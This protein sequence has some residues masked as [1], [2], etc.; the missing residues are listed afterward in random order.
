MGDVLRTLFNRTGRSGLNAM[1]YADSWYSFSST[2]GKMAGAVFRVRNST[3][4]AVIWTPVFFY[5]C[6]CAGVSGRVLP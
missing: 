2:N 3:G 4:S 6:N 5:S 1:V